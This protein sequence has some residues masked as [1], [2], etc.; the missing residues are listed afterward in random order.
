MRREDDRDSAVR[1]LLPDQRR[2]L[3]PRAG[4]ESGKRL[5]EYEQVR[6]GDKRTGQ[7]DFAAFTARQ[8]M[9]HFPEQGY[10]IERARDG[11][12]T[13][14]D[15]GPRQA[16]P[17]HA[18]GKILLHGWGQELSLHILQHCADAKPYRIEVAGGIAPENSNRA[19]ADPG[20]PQ[21]R[22]QQRALSTS[23]RPE[24]GNA[25]AGLDE[26]LS[27]GDRHHPPVRIPN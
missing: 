18:E 6:F 7:R 14:C 12:D 21:N 17:G 24:E 2:K 4:V 16:A 5:V 13:L 9:G 10:E 8:V 15:R 27:S 26:E 25:L 20:K 22:P 23:I 11:G 3:T 1:V 19:T